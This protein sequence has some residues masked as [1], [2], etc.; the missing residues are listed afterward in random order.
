MPGSVYFDSSVFLAV[1]KGDPAAM[2]IR[3]LVVELQRERARIVT[4]A[5]TLQEISVRAS[6]RG[7]QKQYSE[8]VTAMARIFSVERDVALL[9]ARL[10]GEIL[11]LSRDGRK[12]EDNPRRK[13]D[14][15][16]LATAMRLRCG[17]FYTTDKRLI[18]K[19][20]VFGDDVP[21]LL[22][23][24][25]ETQLLFDVSSIPV[26]PEEIDEAEPKRLAAGPRDDSA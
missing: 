25:P 21:R 22:W 2:D 1:L 4:S 7:T 13:W 10:E 19:Q 6:Q 8:L 3:G 24:S 5:L 9:A 20:Q 12:G 18:G 11:R 23:P 17:R 26:A 14:C 15:F 16:H